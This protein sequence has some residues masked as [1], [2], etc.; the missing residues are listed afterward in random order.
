[1]GLG[2]SWVK[3]EERLASFLEAIGNR[4]ALKPPAF[5]W[6]DYERRGRVTITCVASFTGPD[7]GR[8]RFHRRLVSRPEPRSHKAP[9]IE[10]LRYSL[11]GRGR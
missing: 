11:L 1:M 4:T 7:I 5:C 6:R 9:V 3:G 10:R 2:G 8:Y